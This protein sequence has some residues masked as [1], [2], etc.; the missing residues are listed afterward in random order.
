MQNYGQHSTPRTTPFPING[1]A[2]IPNA[3]LNHYSAV[4]NANG[5]V[6]TTWQGIISNVQPNGNG[7]LVTLAYVPL[8]DSGTYGQC[9]FIVDSDYTEQYQVNNDG[10]F[11]YTGSF[12]PEGRAGQ[13]PEIATL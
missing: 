8:L 5:C 12:D 1:N 10:S 4:N 9:C 3:R 11:Q 2:F 7:N 6:I 13:M